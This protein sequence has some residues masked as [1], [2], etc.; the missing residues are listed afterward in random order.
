MSVPTAIADPHIPWAMVGIRVNAKMVT[1][2][3]LMFT[4][5]AKV[6]SELS[7]SLSTQSANML[8]GAPNNKSPCFAT[9]IDECKYPDQ[10]VCYGVCKNTPGSF[11]CQCNT[12]YTGNASIPNGCTGI[13]RWKS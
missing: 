1:R 3:I 13:I 7:L 8:F 11:I 12:G 9:D 5:D 10:Y 6:T 4:V 2:V